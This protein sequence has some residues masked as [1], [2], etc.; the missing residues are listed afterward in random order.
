MIISATPVAGAFLIEPERHADQR[1]YFA[2]IFGRREFLER[3][4]AVDFAHTSV[5]FNTRR[6]TLRGLHFQAPPHAE[7]KLVRCTRGAVWDVALDLRPE[8]PTRTCGTS[9]PSSQPTTA[10]L[11]TSRKGARTDS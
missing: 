6:G 3:G 4:L 7:V 5:S 8:S 2:R 9:A 11:S 10:K 1:G